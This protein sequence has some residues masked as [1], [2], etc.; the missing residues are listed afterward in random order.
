[1][2]WS[3]IIILLAAAAVSIFWKP[4]DDKY[5]S[6]NPEKAKKIIVPLMFTFGIL[7]LI[8]SLITLVGAGK[9][10]VKVLFGSVKTETYL[11]EGAHLVN[12]FLEIRKVSVRTQTYTMSGDSLEGQKHG[13]DALVAISSDALSLKIEVSVLYRV[14]PQA[15]AWVYQKFGDE[16]VESII[17]PSVRSSIR[18]A[19]PHFLAQEAY[20][21]KREELQLLSEKELVTSIN[22]LTKN[23]GYSGTAIE[24]QQVLI[25][26]IQLPISVK[27]SIEQKI[28]AEQDALKMDF[29]IQKERKEAIRKGVEAEGIRNFQSIV[30]QGITPS[31]LQWKGIEATE[32]LASSP[33]SKVVVIGSS[34]DGLPII[35]G[36]GAGK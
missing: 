29:V 7:F 22:S 36:D 31:L 14:L 2:I 24:I 9:V 30:S 5:S 3:A 13:D 34:K 19:A 8:F 1:M 16:W 23:S 35:L 32:K 17:R 11:P 21:Q 6:Y 12:P 28:S 33:N 10:G 18:N 15:A 27:K 25:R 4:E 26:D 20:A